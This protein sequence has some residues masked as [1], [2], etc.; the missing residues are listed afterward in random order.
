[1]V[2]L[3]KTASLRSYSSSCLAG[4][5][6]NLICRQYFTHAEI[7]VNNFAKAVT[8]GA[9]LVD[10]I[11]ALK[12]LPTW[13]PLASFH[14]DA[15]Y[16]RYHFRQ[17][18][19]VPFNQVKKE[20]ASGTAVPS[21]TSHILEN[22]D[23]LSDQT[24]RAEMEEILKMAC[25]TMYGAG[26]DTMYAAT[27]SFFLAMILYPDVQKKAQAELDLIIGTDRL[28]TL[29]D[30][31]QLPYVNAL[32][33][34][35]LR[36]HMPAPL[37]IP[38][39]LSEDDEYNGRR[40]PANSVVLPNLWYISRYSTKLDR[41]DEFIPER[42][43]NA[44]PGTIIDPYTYVFGFGRRICPGRYVAIN[45]LFIVISSVLAAFELSKPAD[46]NGNDLPF[47]PKFNPNAI[48]YPEPFECRI[49]PRSNAIVEVIRNGQLAD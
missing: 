12:Y 14:K 33:Q 36:W 49:R 27:L 19:E 29:Q 1:M 40:I 8:P 35:V 3:S 4:L 18:A 22:I 5:H 47:D 10:L 39:R 20:M 45:L 28:P 16:A 34:E 41:P 46:G 25:L 17:M 42:F 24:S 32:I 37:A 6:S 7:T 31:D 44:A 2:Y 26:V 13:F 9:Y 38:H 15:A 23:E 30:R 11:P 48:C 21:F 43:I